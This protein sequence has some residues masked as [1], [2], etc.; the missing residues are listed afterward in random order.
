MDN[1]DEI[2]LAAREARRDLKE[3]R[4]FRAEEMLGFL[5]GIAPFLGKDSII[6]IK[7]RSCDN[8]AQSSFPLEGDFYAVDKNEY[9]YAKT[10]SFQNLSMQKIG[11]CVEFSSERQTEM[12]NLANSIIEEDLRPAFAERKLYDRTKFASY[13]VDFRIH[14]DTGKI[15]IE[16]GHK[17]GGDFIGANMKLYIL[18]RLDPG[19]GPESSKRIAKA[20][21][22]NPILFIGAS[23]QTRRQL[24]IDYMLEW[25]AKKRKMDIVYL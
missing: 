10:I 24:D 15:C 19:I 9:C 8:Y 25:I 16:L 17:S 4:A 23:E 14:Q 5:E 6:K 3:G 13:K 20:M 11:S 2:F 12:A 21:K 1:K 18:W 7:C 22:T